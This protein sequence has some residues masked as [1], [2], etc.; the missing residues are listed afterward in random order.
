MEGNRR[1]V[2]RHHPLMKIRGVFIGFLFRVVEGGG[3]LRSLGAFKAST[4]LVIA[5]FLYPLGAVKATCALEV[6]AMGAIDLVEVVR[7]LDLVEV[8]SVGTLDV[9]GLSLNILISQHLYEWIFNIIKQDH[10]FIT[11]K[12]FI[13]RIFFIT[14]CFNNFYSTMD[15]SPDTIN[16]AFSFLDSIM[17]KNFSTTQFADYYG[18]LGTTIKTIRGVRNYH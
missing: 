6:D 4:P 9:V 8:E 2:T 17:D 3:A 14:G 12:T 16:F 1:I 13:T 11:K 5:I 10:I 15:K 18:V 7:A